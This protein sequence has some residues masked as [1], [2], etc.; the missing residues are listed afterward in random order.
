MITIDIAIHDQN[1][2]DE[3]L[4]EK[5]ATQIVQ[6]TTL[7]LEMQDVVSELSLVLTDDAE[8]CRLNTQ[9]RH[10]NKVTNVL[11]FSAFS[12]KAGERPGPML[13]D[14]ILAREILEREV[15]EQ[16]KSFNNHFT[17]LFIHGL[18]HLLGYDH[19]D[20]CNAEIMENLERKIMDTLSLTDKRRDCR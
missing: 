1:W 19:S 18:L 9:W 6:V 2:P 8:I 7:H 17:H 14:I 16:E 15:R 12:I 5:L 10:E 3:Q 20:D 11:A 13:G 4:L